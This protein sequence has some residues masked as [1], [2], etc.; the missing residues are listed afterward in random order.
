MLT[1]LYIFLEEDFDAPLYAEPDPGEL[2]EGLWEA[3]CDV[4]HEALDGDGDLDGS[5]SAGEH[6]VAWRTRLSTGVSFV[7]VARQVRVG[8]L[9]A[10]LTLL[11]QRYA[12]EIED[13]REPEPGGVEDVV[14]D[15]IPPWED[16]VDE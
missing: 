11:A 13:P 14:A 3:V 6:L 1:G 15:V 5:V 4:V 8:H 16:A 7:V 2:D 9:L 12:D 10:Y